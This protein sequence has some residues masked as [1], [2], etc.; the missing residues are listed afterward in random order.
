MSV[1]GHFAGQVCSSPRRWQTQPEPFSR[2]LRASPTLRR[3]LRAAIAR[4]AIFVKSQPKAPC[5]GK[6]QQRKQQRE[7][8]SRSNQDRAAGDLLK[9]QDRNDNRNHQRRQSVVEVDRSEKE[10]R[11]AFVN[12]PA[13]FAL[14][15]HRKPPPLHAAF[16][17]SRTAK[18]H[19]SPY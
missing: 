8:D 3:S 1:I 5:P 10:A 4:V 6:K 13:V 18:C 16:A 15:L 9:K 19:A 17:A 12:D 14:W 2:S 11:L 7:R